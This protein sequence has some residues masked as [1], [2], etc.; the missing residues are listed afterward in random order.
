MRRVR[1]PYKRFSPISDTF[2]VTPFGS[3]FRQI[4]F[5]NSH[6]RYHQL[7]SPG[8]LGWVLS[9]IAI[10]RQQPRSF[11]FARRSGSI[12]CRLE[13][14]AKLRL[15]YAADVSVDDSNSLTSTS[16]KYINHQES[17]RRD[18][19]RLQVPHGPAT[20]SFSITP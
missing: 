7:R 9:D 19:A 8:L 13:P 16:Q 5:F 6:R 2:L 15:R 1:M 4:E 11:R 3:V 12:A 17:P 10:F 14:T 18:D 20:K